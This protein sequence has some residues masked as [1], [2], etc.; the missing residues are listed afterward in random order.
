MFVLILWTLLANGEK[1]EP[2]FG[3][4]FANLSSC[5][6]ALEHLQLATD[7]TDGYCYARKLKIDRAYSFPE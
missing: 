3:G 6:R 1:I 4:E 2:R 5:R 7:G